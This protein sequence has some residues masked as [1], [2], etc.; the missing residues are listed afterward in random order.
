MQF[1]FPSL[2]ILPHL[3]AKIPLLLLFIVAMHRAATGG[4]ERHARF[5]F[6][7]RPRAGVSH[8]SC[9]TLGVGDKD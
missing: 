5:T 8:L 3:R 1:A 7:Q 9:V 2:I 6:H 4:Q